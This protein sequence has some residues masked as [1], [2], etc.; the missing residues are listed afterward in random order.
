MVGY[1][2]LRCRGYLLQNL[3]S[4]C[5]FAG[6]VLVVALPMAVYFIKTPDQFYARLNTEGILRNG[7]MQSQMAAGQTYLGVLWQ[8]FSAST[9]VYVARPATA[10]FFNSPLPYMTVLASVFFVLGLSYAL[11]RLSDPRYMTLLAWFWS[12]VILGSTLT[13]GP[14]SS[15]RLLMSTPPLALLVAL[16]LQKS[17]NLLQHSRLISARVG[18]GLC[19]LVVVLTAGQG[20]IYYFGDYRWGHYF[21]DPSNDFSYEVAVK[22]E[23][24]GPNYRMFLLGE[25]SVFASFGDFMFLA[26]DER[27]VDFNTVTATTLAGLPH[28]SGAFFVAVPSRLDDLR[29]V[30]QW[31]PGGDWQAVARRYQ[32]AQ[33]AYFAYIVPP[34]IFATP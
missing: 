12:V 13:M 22:A 9:A 5:I 20:T 33:P 28:D 11:W 21:E 31:V 1:V 14:P 18:L 16:G 32:P 23:A 3:Q 24:L 2:I 29:L 26:H 10:Q 27:I 7:F 25:P 17:A 19:A 15:Q 8:Q 6:A 30:Q 34:Q 4:L